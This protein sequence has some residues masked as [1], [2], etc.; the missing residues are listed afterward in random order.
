[1]KPQHNPIQLRLPAS[2][3]VADINGFGFYVYFFVVAA[4]EAVLLF[5][6]MKPDVFLHGTYES[7]TL[8]KQMPDDPY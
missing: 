6:N 3:T 2:E 7:R 8:P 1:M 5:S 4:A